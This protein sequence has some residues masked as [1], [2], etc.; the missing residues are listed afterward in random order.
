M[1]N[2]VEIICMSQS[3]IKYAE[4][5]EDKLTRRNLKVD[6][7]YPNPDIT[8][9]PL[10]SNLASRKG[11]FAVVVNSGCS[12][13]KCLNVYV[14]QGEHQ[15]HKNMPESD[16]IQFIVRNH[17][18]MV[19]RAQDT[20][21]SAD[22][23][24]FGLSIDL[25]RIFRDIRD[26]RSVTIAEYD[27]AIQ[28]LVSLRESLLKEEYGS[29][30]QSYLLLPPCVP[31]KEPVLRGKQEEVQEYIL[32]ILRKNPNILSETKEKPKQQAGFQSNI[33]GGGNSMAGNM[34]WQHEWQHE[35][36]HV[37]QYEWQYAHEPGR[38]EQA[39]QYDAKFP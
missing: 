22:R 36:Q 34:G 28:H 27:K 11:M 23:P 12:E 15:E 39:I 19:N 32:D 8:L 30:A 33:M 29:N 21:Q 17:Q 31:P 3:F 18:R 38:N 14:L 26:D 2:D 9:G 5:I 1:A 20:F 13:S 6:I 24:H 37:W 4:E 35:W 16:A 25:N 7:L 10:L